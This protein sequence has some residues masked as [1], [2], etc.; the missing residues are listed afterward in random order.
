MIVQ[1]LVGYTTSNKPI[2]QYYTEDIKQISQ[3]V[4]DFSNEDFFD[5]IA[6]F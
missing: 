1:S 4:S 3:D 5:A 6:V 2:Y